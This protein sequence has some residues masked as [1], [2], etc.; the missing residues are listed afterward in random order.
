MHYAVV[1]TT[2]GA[3]G[4]V[5]QGRQLLATYLPQ[6]A[7]GIRRAIRQAWREAEEKADLLPRLRHQIIAFFDGKRTT[8]S[9]GIDLS[10]LPPFR[11]SVLQACR[12]IPYG[13]TMTYADLAQLVGRP[14]AARAVGSAMANNP[15]P[16]VIPC[17]RV[18]RSDGS[19]GGF[20]APEGI[21]QKKRLLQLEG[22]LVCAT[23]A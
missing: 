9:A 17:H 16:L 18:L 23:A 15:V 5:A 8:F 13:E 22:A 20:S 14:G 4:I 10:A 12:Q 3:V 7:A 19:L 6:S 11:Q 1:D 2:W 21:G